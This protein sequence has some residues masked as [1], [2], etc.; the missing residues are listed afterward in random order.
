MSKLRKR[1]MICGILLALAT[2]CRAEDIYH[3][4][5]LNWPTSPTEDAVKYQ[6]YR[7]SGE[8]DF[9][10]LATVTHDPK[11]T[12]TAYLDAVDDPST[13]TYVVTA[14]D[15]DGLQSDGILMQAAAPA[16]WFQPPLMP[17]PGEAQAVHRD[18]LDKVLMDKA[19]L[20]AQKMESSTASQ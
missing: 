6:V 1:L 13:Y 3:G 17:G 16:E 2:C 7:Q 12:T 11:S 19:I 20:R 5:M 15:R 4:I 18:A 14:Q 9:R 10:P 8:S